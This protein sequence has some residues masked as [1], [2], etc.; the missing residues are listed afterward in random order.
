M[1]FYMYWLLFNCYFEG[2]K[3]LRES[4][5]F[6]S[7]IL[8]LLQLGPM[9]LIAVAARGIIILYTIA[10]FPRQKQ[11]KP[12]GPRQRVELKYAKTEINSSQLTNASVSTAADNAEGKRSRNGPK[13]MAQY[14]IHFTVI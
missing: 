1:K 6:L 4:S 10:H 12:L 9:P 14:L 3:G 13:I 11:R 8:L 7:T 2:N 5:P